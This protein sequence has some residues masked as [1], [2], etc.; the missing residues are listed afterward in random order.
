MASE[1]NRRTAPNIR[2]AALILKSLFTVSWLLNS[3]NERFLTVLGMQLA[4][5]QVVTERP[6]LR[7]G[8][9]DAVKR[10]A[11]QKGIR[12]GKR[13]ILS[14]RC[15]RH[16]RGDP[17]KW[18]VAHII[19]HQNSNGTRVTQ[20]LAEHVRWRQEHESVFYSLIQL[21][22]HG[23]KRVTTRSMARRVKMIVN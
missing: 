9:W 17:N 19:P 16:D 23:Y 5:E 15:N 4:A 8:F 10:Y 6:D 21:N 20:S 22:K 12:E 18:L 3:I 2:S 13:G 7:M 1:K 14:R 11:R